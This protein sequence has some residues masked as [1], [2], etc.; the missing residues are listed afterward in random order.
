MY[1]VLGKLLE[2]KIYFKS[3]SFVF[4]GFQILSLINGTL[5]FLTLFL[6]FPKCLY[7]QDFFKYEERDVVPEGEKKHSG[8]FKEGLFRSE[9]D[10]AKLIEKGTVVRVR[11]TQRTLGGNGF[12]RFYPNFCVLLN[13]QP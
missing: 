12:V 11:I 5:V 8:T 7:D 3:N 9:T 6:F 2:Q 10:S 13:N 1:V 4:I